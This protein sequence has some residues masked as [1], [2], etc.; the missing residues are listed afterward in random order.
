MALDRVFLAQPEEAV[1]LRRWAED[2]RKTPL[3]RKTSA[4]AVRLIDNIRDLHQ[5]L[6]HRSIEIPEAAQWV[7]KALLDGTL[8]P[9]DGDT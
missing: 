6:H 7:R 8:D 4:F 9:G 2:E 3:E 1:R 5:A